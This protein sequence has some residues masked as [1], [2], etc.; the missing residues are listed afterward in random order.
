MAD[1]IGINDYVADFIRDDVICQLQT[2]KPNVPKAPTFLE[3]KCADMSLYDDYAKKQEPFYQAHQTVQTI[4]VP[5]AFIGYAS[6]EKS[7]TDGYELAEIPFGTVSERRPLGSGVVINANSRA[8]YYT[9]PDTVWHY[10][11]TRV[12]AA[13]TITCETYE[14]KDVLRLAYKGKPC[15][16]LAKRQQLVVEVKKR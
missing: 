11:T 14:V 8:M 3:V 10:F 5:T 9:G 13:E 1:G 15:Y 16:S 6:V 12:Q 7:S 4:S 2:Y